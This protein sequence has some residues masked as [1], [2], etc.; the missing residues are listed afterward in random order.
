MKDPFGFYLGAGILIILGT[1]FIIN[2][3]VV[4]GIFP[5]TGI[6]LPFVSYG[7]SSILIVLISLGILVN[8]TRKEN[9]G[10]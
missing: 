7:G 4:T 1:Q 6:S 8:I 2:M 9:L 3:F 10:L 5:I